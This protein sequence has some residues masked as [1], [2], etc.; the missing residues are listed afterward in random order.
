MF[1]R[2]VNADEAVVLPQPR[3]RP[4]PARALGAAALSFVVVAGV[5]FAAQLILF[6]ALRPMQAGA[7]VG[8]SQRALRPE[9][10]LEISFAGAGVALADVSL[11]RKE[12]AAPGA[13]APEQAV[14]VRAEPAGAERW[15]II[16]ADGGTPLRPDGVYRLVVRAT[17]LRPAL[18]LPQ[19]TA[20]DREYR[21][22]T[23]AGPR[24]EAPAEPLRPRWAEPV[25]LTW[26]MP[27]E[28]VGASVQPAA[29]L[30]TWIDAAAPEK[31][32]F[33]LGD[34]N[35]AGLVDGQTYDIVVTG[36]RS[37]DG[38]DVQ[39]PSSFQVAVP[40]RPTVANLPTGPVMVK[41]GDLLSL[42][43]SAPLDR[44]D[45][46]ADDGTPLAAAIQ[47]STVSVSLP[48]LGQ[49]QQ[50]SVNVLGAWSKQGAPQATPFRIEVRTPPPLPAPVVEPA[51]QSM[52]V[53]PR[54][55][56]SLTFSEPVPDRGAVERALR[57]EP[58]VPGT[59]QWT[60]PDRVEFASADRLPI[61][62]DFTVTLSGG[63]DGP[64]SASGG[65]LEEDVV[66]AFR[67]TDYK[68]I[69]VSLSRQRLYMLED[70]Q[71]IRTIV[72]GTGV[73]GAETPLGTYEVLYKMVKTRM[74]GVNPSG[75]TYDIPD[76]PW[77]M[78]FL[79]DYAIHG[80]YWRS[81]FGTVGSNGCVGMSVP[82]AKIL[83]DWS[84]VGTPVVVRA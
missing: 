68:Q 19:P 56:P 69:D 27:M 7:N 77:V 26:S 30:R 65:Y 3:L 41:N 33:Q 4:R 16:A 70:G 57:I 40:V 81:T 79:G 20:V 76:V 74:R 43:S 28:S 71:V 22:S 14:P 72:V 52:R 82:E 35:G 25:A 83:Y 12:A 32:W 47:G 39:Q 2:M 60:A 17:A 66:S 45:V 31:T 6:S 18:P 42:A 67:T 44:V 24:L 5:W 73:A 64:R 59:W 80:N 34:E 61:F 38:L 10:P 23:V 75:K 8:G 9:S 53:Q 51:D 78:P 84:S 29:P 13:A 58:S 46:R 36:A 37:R 54:A 21:F 63:P 49:D 62:T 50:L 11:L 55:R 1:G 48:V 15:R